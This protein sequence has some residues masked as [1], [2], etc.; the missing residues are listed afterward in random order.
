MDQRDKNQE[1]ELRTINR[2]SKSKVKIKGVSLEDLSTTSFKLK[3]LV[4]R[5]EKLFKEELQRLYSLFNTLEDSREIVVPN[6]SPAGSQQS[7]VWDDQADLRSPLK[8]TSD[9]LDTSFNFSPGQEESLPPAL[10]RDRST[11]VSVN[12]ADYRYIVGESGDDIIEL[13]A[14]T[15]HCEGLSHPVS[16]DELQEA[17]SELSEDTILERNFGL[18][19]VE[20]LPLLQEVD[21]EMEEDDYKKELKALKDVKRRVERKIAG[22]TAA[23]VTAADKDDYKETLKTTRTLYDAFVAKVDNLI[24]RLEDEEKIQEVNDLLDELSVKLKKNEKEVKEKLLQVVADYDASKPLSEADKKLKAEK[25]AKVKTRIGFIKEKAVDFKNGILKLKVA[26][27]MSDNEIRENMVEVKDW[28]IKANELV[29]SKEK[30][31]EDSVGIDIDPA[32]VLALKESVQA[33]IDILENKIENLKIEDKGRGLFTLTKKSGDKVVFPEA[34]EGKAGDNVF[35]FKEKFTRALVDSQTR[36]G[37]KVEVLRQHLV[38]E[39]KEL[40]GDHHTSLDTAMRAL[41]DYFGQPKRI[42]FKSKKDIR[43]KLGGKNAWGLYGSQQR[44]VAIAQLLEFLREAE[45]LSKSYKELQTEIYHSSTTE[46]LIDLMP[47]NYF[48][49]VND[50]TGGIRDTE[51]ENIHNIKEFLEERKSSAIKA[52]EKFKEDEQQARN[53]PRGRSGGQTPSANKSVDI[54]PHDCYKSKMCKTK[55]DSLGCIEF[56]KLKSHEDRI[57]WMRD[58][59]SCFSC[60]SSFTP[61]SNHQCNWHPHDKLQAQCILPFCTRS[62]ALCGI[63]HSNKSKELIDWLESCR[64]NTK[65]LTQVG[66]IDTGLQQLKSN[67]HN[68]RENEKKRSPALNARS[69]R[70][71]LQMGEAHKHLSDEELVPFFTE[72]MRKFERNPKIDPI[73]KGEPVFIFCVFKG[74]NGPVMVFIDSGCNFWLAE[75]GIPETELVSCKLADGPI[76]MGVAGGMTVNAEAE[77]SSLIPLANGNHQIVRGLTVPK[78]TQ[79]MDEINLQKVFGIIK[80]RCRTNSEV[81]NLKVPNV[82]GGRINMI[83]GIKYQN[84]YPIPVHQ[85]PNGLTVFKSQL[86]PVVPGAIACIGGPVDALNNIAGALGGQAA[87]K[88]MSSLVTDLGKYKSKIDFFPTSYLDTN[89]IDMDIPDVH[90]LE[91]ESVDTFKVCDDDHENVVT[92]KK[93]CTVCGTTESTAAVQSELQRFLK[94]QDVG[95]DTSYRCRR[96]RDCGDCKKGSGYERMSLLQEAEQEL[97]KDSVYIDKENKRAVAYLPFKA[98][99]KE[100]LVDNTSIATK[101]LMNV[102]RKYHDDESVKETINKAFEKLRKKGHLKYYED[103]SDDQVEKLESAPVGYTIPWDVVWKESSISTPARTVFDASSKTRSG[104]SLNDLLATGI[105][106]IV[107]LMELVLDWQVGPVA[108]VGDVSQFYCTI[109]LNEESWPFQKLLLREDLNPHGRLIK[110]VIIACIFGV[111]SSGGQSEEVMRMVANIVKDAFPE[112]YKLLIKKRYIDDFGKSNKN[113]VEAIQLIKDTEKALKDVNMEIKGWSISGEKPDESLT[114]DGV[115]IKFAGMCWLPEIDAVKLNIQPLHFGKKKRGRFPPNL[116]VFDGKMCLDQFVPKH[117]SRRNCTSVVARIYDLTGKLAPLTLKFK[118][119]LRRLIEENP[120][121]DDALSERKRLGWLV[122]FR[123]VE[124]VRD[125]MYLRSPVPVDAIDLKARIWILC[126]AADGGIMIAVYCCFRLPSNRWSCANLLG[127]GLLA[128]E[129]TI[130]KKELHALSSASDVKIIVERSMSDWITEIYVGGDSEISLAWV[131]YE[132]VKLNVFHRNRVNNIRSKVD[133]K[134]LHHV[135]GSENPTDC[136]TRPDKVKVED[137]MPGSEWLNGK[138]WMKLPYEDAIKSGVI[139]T[140]QDIKLS[141]DEK[142]IM[143]EGIV[144]DTFDDKDD[145]NIAVAMV[146]SIDI[147]K[148]AEREAYSDYVYPPLKRS[149]KPTVRII[150]MVLLAVKKFKKKLLMSKIRAGKAKASDLDK[151]DSDVVKFTAFHYSIDD[152][153]EEKS[154]DAELKLTD[155]FAINGV[156]CMVGQWKGK[157]MNVRLTDQD[158]SSGLDYLFKKATREILK[159]EDKKVIDKQAVMMDGILYSKN[160]ILEGAT[161]RAVGALSECIDLET[162]TGIKFQVPMIAK[163]SPLA[164]S[165]AMH[166]HYNVFKH[167]GCETVHRMSLQ[168]VNIL[169]GRQLFKEIADDCVFCKKKRLEYVKQLMGPLTE[170]QLSI[171][172]I[173]YA[174]LLDMWGPIEIFCP[175]YEK[176]TRN[177]RNKYEVHMLVMGCAATGTINC[178][179]IE[180]KDTGGVLDGLNRFFCEVSVPKICYPDKD[181]ALMKALREGEVNLQ[182]LQ[183]RLHRERGIWFETCAAQNHSAHGRIE[184]RI[185]MV[186]D[187]LERS[188]MKSS[189]NTATGWQTI[190]KAVEREVNNIPLGFLYHQGTGNPLLRVLCP[191]LLKNSTFSDRAPKGLFSIPN[192][193]ESLMTKIEDTYNLWF[194]IWNIDY[195]PLIMLRQKWYDRSENLTENDLVYFKMTDTPLSADWRLG[196]VEY[197]KIGRDGCI[198]EVGISY[199]IMEED[200]KTP[201]EE[202]GWRHSVVERPARAVVKL[203][204]LEDT[205]ILDDMKQVRDLAKEITSQRKFTSEDID[206]FNKNEKGEPIFVD[207]EGSDFDEF[208]GLTADDDKQNLKLS[209]KDDIIDISDSDAANETEVE[210]VKPKFKQKKKRKT[211]LE[212][213]EIDNDEF[214]LPVTKPR[215]TRKRFNVVNMMLTPSPDSVDELSKDV[216]WTNKKVA[217]IIASN[218]AQNVSEENLSVHSSNAA[219]NMMSCGT[220]M[221]LSVIKDDGVKISWPQIITEDADIGKVTM[222]VCSGV[223]EQLARGKCVHSDAGGGTGDAIEG[224][225]GDIFKCDENMIHALFLI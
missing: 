46:L 196:K 12:R 50:L 118:Y 69:E 53:F 117:L 81:Q 208:D 168:H 224:F 15:R 175:G 131:I 107:K 165:I 180:K 211:E 225:G 58:R 43:E 55:W 214:K 87:L 68:K 176:V 126:D 154:D 212:K 207:E 174:T 37:D 210:V 33:T 162:F 7:L 109:R 103:L 100:F 223:T 51:E 44:V 11:S 98:D 66:V 10:S 92:E 144:F 52:T 5:E 183:G 202:L 186:Q 120:S 49:K 86:L 20:A 74:R 94:L 65:H 88:Y 93:V 22:Y 184:R 187:S 90:K 42:W 78:V 121:W 114:D 150:S 164:V 70:E 40:I 38:G 124:D 215:L 173:F 198:R 125:V 135:Q 130:P 61:N 182:D 23:D 47:R 79:D 222:A 217:T 128:P 197:T 110:A 59:R 104:Y 17:L 19:E 32:D 209:S 167:R 194:Q 14:V 34:F 3:A 147:E 191:S 18:P 108:F 9:L 221:C 96:C 152:I 60:G 148:T 85:F 29:S 31:I 99:P 219:A 26:K 106:D 200:H 138:E 159:F 39:A 105:P 8:D 166:L 16:A 6:P 123:M 4:S 161:L 158:L 206:E 145:S 142:K 54:S 28:K 83:L 111:C 172:P 41:V 113:K 181:G 178:Q 102:C 169:K 71:K 27:D 116:K 136:G 82:V 91:E 56:Y 89:L 143:R 160:R 137:V 101:R 132:N 45:A 203:F 146:N 218:Y 151:V 156:E 13:E 35:K 64:V 157:K 153:K 193:P 112:V 177:R 1:L 199:S 204:N 25:V 155:A 220:G 190:A 213:L 95:L 188:G 201:V 163:H 129:W 179:I 205:N 57:K 119:D 216:A 73:P 115:S 171:S 195:I 62:A 127:K 21:V 63:H 75:S 80:K 189:K 170:T 36:E 77:W 48:E 2:K 133:L 97:I 67:T 84:I 141:N 192:S 30:T 122:N 24:D 139:K 72:D 134:M 76:P 140:V 185:R 149:W